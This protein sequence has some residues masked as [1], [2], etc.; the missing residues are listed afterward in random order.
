VAF[1]DGGGNL[2]VAN[3]DGSGRT[4]AARNP[5]GEKW[6]HPTWRT[7]KA[8]TQINRPARNNIFFASTAGGG[9]LWEVPMD[10][11]DAQPKQLSLN[12]YAGRFEV[13]PPQA[14]NLWPSAAGMYGS[15][16][17]EHDDTSSSDV[18]VRDEFL[19]QQGGLVIKDAAEPDYVLIGGSDSGAP[20][21]VFV[22]KVGGHEHVFIQTIQTSTG[23]GKVAA[24][25]LTPNATTDCTEPAI[26]P[27]GKTVAFSTS[28]E[29]EIVPTD[30]SGAPKQVTNVPGFPAFRAGS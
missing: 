28:S 2:V 19:R 3:A 18:Y 24:R 30:G 9:T 26:S 16:V 14:G 8:D 13:M 11:H 6:S 21:V 7:T 23:G 25:D 1:I 27:D 20:E 4:E 15:A 22:R 12:G 17:Y 5:G 29:V 10:A